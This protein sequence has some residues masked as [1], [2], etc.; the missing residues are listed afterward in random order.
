MYP[1]GALQTGLIVALDQQASET[2]RARAALA[3]ELQCAQKEA[4]A[5]RAAAQ[6]RES[7]LQAKLSRLQE[8]TLPFLTQVNADYIACDEL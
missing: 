1:P 7:R 8:V 3:E 6:A 2:S 4:A 5:G